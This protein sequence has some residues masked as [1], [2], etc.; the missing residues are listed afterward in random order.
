MDYIELNG[1]EHPFWFAMK[2]QR[3]MMSVDME[4]KDDI[5]LIWLGLKYG[6]KLEKVE[7]TLSEDDLLDIF[8]VNK[9]QFKDAYKLLAKQ[10]GELRTLREIE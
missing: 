10:M 9:D 4:G 3:E 5:Y 6:A 2:A 7:F 8:E 1:K